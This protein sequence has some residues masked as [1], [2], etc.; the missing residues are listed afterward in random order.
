MLDARGNTIVSRA[1][2][3][4][5]VIGAEGMVV[6]DTPDALLVVPRDQAQRVKDVV[7]RLRADG[8]DDVL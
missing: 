8:R 7:D 4:I 5:A 6:V 1:G 3:L 2:R